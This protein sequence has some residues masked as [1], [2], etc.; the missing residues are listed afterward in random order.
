MS[1]GMLMCTFFY[2]EKVG[3]GRVSIFISELAAREDR[4]TEVHWLCVNAYPRLVFEQQVA[5]YNLYMRFHE[6]VGSLML[7]LMISLMM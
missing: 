3:K 5:M 6:L 4:G 7:S 1:C 2:A